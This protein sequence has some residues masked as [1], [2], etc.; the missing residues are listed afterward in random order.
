[1][2]SITIAEFFY[3]R[4][5]RLYLYPQARQVFVDCSPQDVNI[6]AKILMNQKISHSF[7]L[8]ISSKRNYQFLGDTNSLLQDSVF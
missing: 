1:M 2:I 6:N 7:D 5:K 8:L 3:I 4:V